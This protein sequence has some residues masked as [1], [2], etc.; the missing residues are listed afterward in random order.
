MVFMIGLGWDENGWQFRTF[1]AKEETL[2]AEREIFDE[3]LDFLAQ[4]TGGAFTDDKTTALYHWTPP[5]SWQSR[6]AA[7]RHFPDPNH[8]LRRLP[9]VDLQKNFIETPCCVPG[10]LSF[11]LKGTAKNLGKLVPELDPH[12]PGSLDEGTKAMV[13]G[14]KGYHGGDINQS[15][16]IKLLTPYLEADCRAVCNVL[17]WMRSFAP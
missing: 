10:E 14:W 7:D 3:F 2:T 6:R 11:D 12:W 4:K 1:V 15:E 9:L 16:E 13:M 17:R 8:P 5:E